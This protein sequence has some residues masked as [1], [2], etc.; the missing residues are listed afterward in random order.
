MKKGHT[1]KIIGRRVM[2]LD[3]N[4]VDFGVEYIFQGDISSCF[5]VMDQSA[6]FG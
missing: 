3:G 4:D 6:Y 2:V 5:Q 1:L